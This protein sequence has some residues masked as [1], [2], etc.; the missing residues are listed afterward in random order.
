MCSC[1]GTIIGFD[2]EYS[3]SSLY[4]LVTKLRFKPCN[5]NGTGKGNAKGNEALRTERLLLTAI[6]APFLF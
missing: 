5:G 6:S 2:G 4:K 3:N 1:R